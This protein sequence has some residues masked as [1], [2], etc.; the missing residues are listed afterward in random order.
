MIRTAVIL[1]VM[2]AQ[3]IF[4]G[5]IFAQDAVKPKSGQGPAK[6]PSSEGSKAETSGGDKGGAKESTYLDVVHAREKSLKLK[7]DNLRDI[8]LLNAMGASLPEAFDKSESEKIGNEYK[9]ALKHIYRMEYVQAEKVLR[10]NRENIA[11]AMGRASEIYRKKTTDMLNKSADR[12]ADLDMAADNSG[13][14]EAIRMQGIVQKNQHRLSVGYQQLTLAANAEKHRRY[15][16][17]LS[18]YRLA[19]LHSIYLM[20]ELAKDDAEKNKLRAEFRSELDEKYLKKEDKKEPVAA[21]AA[22]AAADKKPSGK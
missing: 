9:E 19:R 15:A 14:A 5:A 8:Q 7:D 16:E 6:K 18:H 1:L 12:M 3:P 4:Y 17:A 22:P 21:G 20:I 11:K 2:L 10:E 13:S